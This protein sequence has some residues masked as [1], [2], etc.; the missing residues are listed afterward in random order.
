MLIFRSQIQI[1]K[2]GNI[3]VFCH[4]V[5]H[6][7]LLFMNPSTLSI[8]WQLYRRVSSQQELRRGLSQPSLV[9]SF[10]CQHQLSAVKEQDRTSSRM[11]YCKNHH[12]GIIEMNFLE[13]WNIQ[14]KHLPKVNK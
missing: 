8:H 9:G 13:S 10:H 12:L 2:F 1:T 5:I 6:D 7:P 14:K 11:S 3:F 4:E